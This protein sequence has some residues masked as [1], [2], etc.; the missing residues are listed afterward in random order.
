MGKGGL[1]LR[2]S[3]LFFE[4]PQYDFPNLPQ[5]DLRT[6]PD[7]IFRSYRAPHGGIFDPE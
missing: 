2:I 1:K 4:P 7:T 6:Y 5:Y 3:F